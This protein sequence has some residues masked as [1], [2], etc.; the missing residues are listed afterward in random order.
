LKPKFILFIILIVFASLNNNSFSQNKFD[1]KS[2]A[3]FILDIVKYVKWSN[4]D[5]FAEFKI[6]IL[7]KDKSLYNELLSLSN[8]RKTVH[9]KPIIVEIYN[10]Y[11]E[12]KNVQVLFA[13][14]ENG[15]NI[16]KLQDLVTKKNILLIT[17]NYEFHKSMINFIVVNNER[18][19]EMNE[20]K[21]KEEGFVVTPLFS[22]LAVKSK[23]DWEELYRKTDIELRKEKEIVEQQIQIIDSQKK[24]IERQKQ[25]IEKQENILIKQREEIAEREKDIA[26][27]KNELQ[28]LLLKVEESN[29]ILKEKLNE[30]E[31]QKEDLEVQ[32]SQ[33]VRQSKIL[34]SQK[35][36][37]NQQESRINAQ[38]IVLSKQLE[39]IQMQQII[40]YLF[41]ALAFVLAGLGFFIY[42]AYKIKKQSNI[43]LTEKNHEILQQN[44]EIRQQKEE[45]E[46]QR[47]EI[48]RNRDEIECQ[49][50]LAIQ[51]RDE[52]IYQKKE[53]TDSIQYARRIQQAVLPPK[54]F[55]EDIMKDNFFIYN[56][57]RDIVSGDYYWMTEKDN[58]IVIAA[59]DCTGHGVPGAFMSLLG[60]AF[61]NEIINKNE[62]LSAA[63]ILDELRNYVIKALHQ[64]GRDT[65]TRDGMDMALCL[66]DIKT[67]SLQYSGANNPL[68][69][70]RNGELI[71][72]KADKMPIGLYDEA[73]PFTNNIIQLEKNDTFYIFSDG[74]ADQFGGPKA[75]EGGK[76]FK[77]SK[78]KEL[79]ITI[80]SEKMPTQLIILDQT[81]KDWQQDLFQVD[82]MLIIGIRV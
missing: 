30:L 48:G 66:L 58:E 77:Y 78:F 5:D 51:Q 72:Y 7:D 73:K 22:A 36:E 8:E 6:G 80:Q 50:N 42:R 55:F 56:K 47:D 1:D 19:F 45:I 75:K 27:Q 82:D 68:Y 62:K 20:T 70:I 32:K 53:I 15:Y 44:E 25:E 23:A 26:L 35:A 29:L 40:L 13:N 21:L 57:P 17:E 65:Q 9:N 31:N 11:N 18:R 4:I 14:K 69:L 54:K 3:V 38:R 81:I 49:R 76:K 12:I 41:F 61:L 52:I 39:Q 79:L 28:K 33:I 10:H 63:Q 67:L 60:V 59:A 74:Y 16:Y 43:L 34:D 2:R 64:Q 71:E 24:D 46:A 37:I